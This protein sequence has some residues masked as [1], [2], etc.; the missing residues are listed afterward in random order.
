MGRSVLSSQFVAGLN[1]TLKSKVA[2]AEG[3]FGQ[4]LVK[5]R[6]EEAKLKEFAGA[7]QKKVVVEPTPNKSESE[8]LPPPAPMSRAA[9][10]R[11]D[12]C[13]SPHHL[14]RKCPYRQ[15]GAPGES[16]GKLKP[17]QQVSVVVPRDSDRHQSGQEQEEEVDAVLSET[18]AMMHGVTSKTPNST[19][20]LGPVVTAEVLLEGESVSALVDTGSPVTIVSLEC[21]V[22]TLARKRCP[23][24]SPA[25]WRRE[26]EKR[27]EPPTLAMGGMS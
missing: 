10:L 13:D 8:S 25:Q 11:C 6:F 17:E 1:P 4:L 22:K 24:Q 7:K 27:L 5:A 14:R 23:E 12:M 19:V 3:D 16:R 18:T 26:V 15:R 2:G 21:I 9:G 20:E